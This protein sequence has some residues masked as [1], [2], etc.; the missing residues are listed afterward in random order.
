MRAETSG[1][2]G[3]W[4][5]RL[6]VGDKSVAVPVLENLYGKMKDQPYNV[7]LPALWTAA[8]NRT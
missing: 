2:T 5:R 3:P 4:R 6:K 8:R 1:K 7:D